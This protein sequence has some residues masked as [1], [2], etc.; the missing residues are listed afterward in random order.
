MRHETGPPRHESHQAGRGDRPAPPARPSLE[1]GRAARELRGGHVSAFTLVELIAVVVILGI[2]MVS[3]VVSYTQMVE[4]SQRRAAR[5]L[6][7]AIY[8]GEQAYQAI[9][10]SYYPVGGSLGPGSSTAE[11][12]TIYMENPNSTTLPMTFTVGGVSATDFCAEANWPNG[13]CEAVDESRTWFAGNP[14]CSC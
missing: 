4:R 6:L 11:W 3:G 9:N 8:Y 14:G 7:L 2:L 12:R 5:D 1:P 10:R 13:D